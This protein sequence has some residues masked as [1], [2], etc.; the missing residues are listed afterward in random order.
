ALRRTRVACLEIRQQG[1]THIGNSG[2]QRTGTLCFCIHFSTLSGDER[3]KLP[4]VDRPHH[5][6]CRTRSYGNIGGDSRPKTHPST[7]YLI[8]ALSDVSFP[9]DTNQDHKPYK[10]QKKTELPFSV[11]PSGDLLI[12]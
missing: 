4:P 10:A 11:V 7:E 6:D 12:Q 5:L 8:H 3:S 2:I 9:A 1:K